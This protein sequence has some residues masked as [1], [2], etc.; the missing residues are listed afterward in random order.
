V[1]GSRTTTGSNRRR[2]LRPLPKRITPRASAC[3]YPR[4]ARASENGPPQALRRSR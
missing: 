2:R 4:E 3:S 1:C